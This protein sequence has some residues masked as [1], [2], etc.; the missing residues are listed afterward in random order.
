MTRCRAVQTITSMTKSTPR[1]SNHAAA[2]EAFTRISQAMRSLQRDVGVVSHGAMV[3][4]LVRRRLEGGPV[5]RR[6]TPP[7]TSRGF[8]PMHAGASRT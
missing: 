5:A 3:A 1:G 6:P 4:W 7:G 8:V 2:Q